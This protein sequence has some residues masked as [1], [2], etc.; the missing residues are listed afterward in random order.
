MNRFECGAHLDHS[1][2]DSAPKDATGWLTKGPTQTPM[3]RQ[4]KT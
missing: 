1:R 4:G 3:E 2:H